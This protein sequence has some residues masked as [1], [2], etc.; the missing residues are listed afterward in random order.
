LQLN[1][2]FIPFNLILLYFSLHL[3]NQFHV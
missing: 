3:K 1:L 2:I